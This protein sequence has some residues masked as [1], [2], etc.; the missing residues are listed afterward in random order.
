L[1]KEII[2]N[3]KYRDRGIKKIFPIK[4]D[5]I[6]SWVSTKF[7]EIMR[8]SQK[9]KKL[10][11]EISDCNTRIGSY[12]PDE[13][14]KIDIEFEKIKKLNTEIL[15][16]NSDE[17]NFLQKRF[18]LIKEILESNG[19][20]DKQILTYEFWDRKV[21]PVII[22]DFLITVCLKDIDLKKK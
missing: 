7:S 11:D 19:I 3:L 2:Y 14:D 10:W 21:D 17:N 12:G 20:S 9:T 1:S 6:S 4:I 13:K 18:E 22:I 16:F 8:D 15:T 5:F